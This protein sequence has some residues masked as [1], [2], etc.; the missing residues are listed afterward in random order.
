MNPLVSFNRI[1]GWVYLGIGAILLFTWLLMRHETVLQL[2][3][4]L[5][6]IGGGHLLAARGFQGERSWRWAAQAAPAALL[7]IQLFRLSR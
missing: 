5:A 2:G 6:L 1:L 7:L 3:A 4:I